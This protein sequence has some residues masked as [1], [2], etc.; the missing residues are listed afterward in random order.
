MKLTLVS[1][2]RKSGRWLSVQIPAINAAFLATWALLP[3]KFQDALPPAAFIW[4]A[5]ALIVIG[6]AGRLLD[7]SGVKK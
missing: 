1:D 3:V 2:W 6:V 7:Q 5:I 4:I